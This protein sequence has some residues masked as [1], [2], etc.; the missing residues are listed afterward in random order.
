MAREI[1]VVYQDCVLCGVKGRAK[2]AQLAQKGVKLR[3]VGFST[4]E[5]KDLIR[6]AVL[7][8]GIRTMPFYVE[9]DV[10]TSSLSELLNEKPK[11]VTK[12]AKKSR[13]T[14]TIKNRSQDG[15]DS[16]A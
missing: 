1:I 15:N 4:E 12:T 8:R 3:K 11:K 9:G 10:Y 16:E 14:K 6:E 7:Y 2:I 13:K 5:G